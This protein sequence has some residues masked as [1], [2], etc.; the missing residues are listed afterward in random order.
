MPS[1]SF[2]TLENVKFFVARDPE[3]TKSTRM[4]V[5]ASGSFKMT[6]QEE[7]NVEASC[8]IDTQS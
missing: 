1:I 4:G 3:D 2:N 5:K 7:T 8:E 6:E